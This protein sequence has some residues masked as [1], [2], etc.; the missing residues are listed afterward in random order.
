[1]CV[2]FMYM[3]VVVKICIIIFKDL[4]H[5]DSIIIIKLKLINNNLL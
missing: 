5:V 4:V 2:K 3:F 1:M